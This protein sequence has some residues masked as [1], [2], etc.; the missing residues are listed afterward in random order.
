MLSLH[1]EHGY[2]FQVILVTSLI[3]SAYSGEF[4]NSL[5]HA[6]HTNLLYE[7]LIRLK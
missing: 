5:L 7:R 1:P 4:F 6:Q 2:G 3:T